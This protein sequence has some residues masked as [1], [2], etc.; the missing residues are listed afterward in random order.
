LQKP[1]AQEGGK[2]I[3]GREVSFPKKKR[4]G[5]RKAS[6]IEIQKPK[7]NK[8]KKKKKK[9]KNTKKKQ[10]KKKNTKKKKE[11]KKKTTKKKSGAHGLE[12]KET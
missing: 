1:P 11:K 3:L 7:T 6:P 5:W 9:K 4:Q 8:K 10:K 2:A 12:D